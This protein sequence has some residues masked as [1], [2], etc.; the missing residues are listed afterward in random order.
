MNKIIKLIII[1]I[2]ILFIVFF[3]TEYAVY[4]ISI[5]TEE[6]KNRIKNG[7]QLPKF[8][9]ILDNVKPIYIDELEFYFDGTNDIH[10]GRLPVGLEYNKKPIVIFGCSFALGQYLNFNQN[11]GFKLSKVLKRPVFNRAISGAGISHM[12]YQTSDNFAD[13][14]YKQVPKT[15]TVYYVMIDAHYERFSIFSDYDIIGRNFHLRYHFK[16]KKPIIDDYN[17]KFLNFLKQSY[18]IRALNLKY[19]NWKIRSKFFENDITDE[20]L[21]YFIETRNELEKHWNNKIKFNIIFYD[22]EDFT[23]FIHKELLKKKLKEN[24]FNVIDTKEITNENLKSEKYFM[25]DNYH[26]KEAAWDLLL[27]EIIKY[28]EL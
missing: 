24:G 10:K 3:L 2:L 27:P 26:P 18:I 5:N 28:S 15:D 6:N 13:V 9:Y 11:F 8:E 21:Y 7:E 12:Y 20:V 14:F 16:D 23:P 1:N 25:N 19:I 17:N 4:K 22:F